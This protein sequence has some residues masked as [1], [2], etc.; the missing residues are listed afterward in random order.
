M[1][2]IGVPDGLFWQ[3]GWSF[4]VWTGCMN[5]LEC[6]GRHVC[7]VLLTTSSHFP[8]ARIH[9][10]KASPPPTGSCNRKCN[11]LSVN[12][13]PRQIICIHH[14]RHA[15]VIVQT[16]QSSSWRYH[17]LCLCLNYS[18]SRTKYHL[19]IGTIHNI[20]LQPENF[21]KCTGIQYENRSI[22]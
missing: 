18:I 14:L 12:T 19:D 7:L 20:T 5:R 2:N 3:L 6:V 22:P 16:T 17:R 8:V 10:G 21:S 4:I 9:S 1:G 15:R 11:R 13:H